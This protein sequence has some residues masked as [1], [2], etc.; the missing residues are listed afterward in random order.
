MQCKLL[1]NHLNITMKK[2]REESG[3]TVRM[4]QWTQTQTETCIH[5]QLPVIKTWHPLCHIGILGKRLALQTLPPTPLSTAP[6]HTNFNKFLGFVVVVV[7]G[8]FV[9]CFLFCFVLMVVSQTRVHLGKKKKKDM[10]FEKQRDGHLSAWCYENEGFHH[11]LTHPDHKKKS[12]AVTKIICLQHFILVSIRE[13]K[14]I[15][16]IHILQWHSNWPLGEKILKGL[17]LFKPSKDI[18]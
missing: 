1:A 4:I 8:F 16:A 13:R 2:G 18:F 10:S 15:Y 9:F 3:V 6:I 7:F 12:W 5:L 14:Y 17:H 11:F